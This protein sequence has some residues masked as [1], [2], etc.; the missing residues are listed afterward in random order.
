M[1]KTILLLVVLIGYLL[2]SCAPVTPAPTQTPMPT[3]TP[4]PTPTNNPYCDPEEITS[5][6]NDYSPLLDRF[7]DQTT[8]LFSTPK[9]SLPEQIARLQEIRR[10]LSNLKPGK[11]TVKVL[12]LTND[13][14]EKMVDGFLAYL[15]G[16]NDYATILRAGIDVIKVLTIEI[17]RLNKCLPNCTP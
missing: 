14:T 7:H 17:N 8:L 9:I 4:L 6:F 11:C 15:S 5:F 1:N 3:S 13:M 12:A 10:E 2:I 16:D